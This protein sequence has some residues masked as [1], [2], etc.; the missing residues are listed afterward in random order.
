VLESM[1]RALARGATIHAELVGFGMSADG[2]DI[3]APD[4]DS[5]A[6]AMGFALEDAGLAPE[7]VDYVSAHG[8]ATA[9]NDKTETA[10]L[11]QVF[12]AHLDKLPVSSSKSQYGHTMNASGGLDFVTS[13]LALREG[14][15]PPTMG[16]TEPDPECDLDCVPNASRPAAIET[17]I[18][19]SFAF[20]GL[21]AVL[22]LKRY[23]G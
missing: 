17:A 10:A 2:K 23:N 15:L 19:S 7:R 9:L 21:N 5:A 16:F 18:S 20:G 1:D 8:T 6:A 3:T 13:V 14:F 12:G 4:R 22:A 11:R